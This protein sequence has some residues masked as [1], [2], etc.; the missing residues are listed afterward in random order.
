MNQIEKNTDQSSSK[1]EC[2]GGETIVCRNNCWRAL[3]QQVERTTN[4]N[5]G[6]AP[7]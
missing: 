3:A 2:F 1:E 4:R 7:W 6:A 5:C